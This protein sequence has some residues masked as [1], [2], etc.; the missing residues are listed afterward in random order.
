MASGS[1]YPTSLDTFTDRVTNYKVPASDWNKVQDALE[2]IEAELGIS[3]SGAS[4]TVK[5]AIDLNTT[6]KDASAA[7]HGLGASVNV[8][9]NRDA[10]GEFV[11]R[12]TTNPG[13]AGSGDQPV[14]DVALAITFGT[15][16]SNAP[17]V[18]IAGSTDDSAYVSGFAEKITTTGFSYSG[19]TRTGSENLTDLRYIA[20]GD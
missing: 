6:H 9:G 4:A 14:Y 5:V 13:A 19:L 8:L 11:Q 10:S 17:Y 20:L 15:A 7:I 16:F 1:S 18:S 3:P 12:A 2:N